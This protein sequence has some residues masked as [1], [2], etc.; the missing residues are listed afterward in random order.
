MFLPKTLN[1]YCAVGFILS[2]LICQAEE[3]TITK[4][5]ATNRLFYQSKSLFNQMKKRNSIVADPMLENYL[6]SIVEKLYPNY[7]GY[8]TIYIVRNS[9]VNAFVFP[10]GKVFVTTGL[11]GI[12]EN[13]AQIASVL[14][15]EGA[16]FV[17]KHSYLTRNN[18]ITSVENIVLRGFDIDEVLSTYSKQ[19]EKDADQ[20]GLTNYLGVQY[21]GNQAL[22][23]FKL[24]SRLKK[25][26]SDKLKHE[27]RSHPTIDAR[28]AAIKALIKLKKASGYENISK[29]SKDDY[30][31][32]T[33]KYRLMTYSDFI[34][35][36]LYYKLI[37]LY[38]FDPKLPQM[39]PE[40][41]F[42]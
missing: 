8:F 11:L 40:Y 31:S 24:M 25:P 37:Q 20:I 23:M 27:Y 15:H 22:Y 2:S 41:W 12:A 1:F 19:I 3:I 9:A 30:Q 6:L 14:A 5:E 7:I 33:L 13:E 32:L 18:F 17:S 42:F 39:V 26:N 28:I 4:H 36:Y 38:E 29:N 35:K 16:H 34:Q 21:D 10:N